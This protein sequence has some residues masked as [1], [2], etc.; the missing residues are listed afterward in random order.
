VS[1]QEAR[2]VQRS[3]VIPA[4]PLHGCLLSCPCLSFGALRATG[5]RCNLHLDL[6]CS[7]IPRLLLLSHRSVLIKNQ[8]CH[9]AESSWTVVG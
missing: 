4:A 2:F 1:S 3:V 9:H 5:A 7:L 6:H 8:T